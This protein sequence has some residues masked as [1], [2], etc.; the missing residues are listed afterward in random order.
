MTAQTGIAGLIANPASGRDIRRLVAHASVFGND[1]KINIL[2]RVVLGLEAAGVHEVLYMPDPHR[3][4][5]R[6]LEGVE[7]KT[8]LVPVE[9]RLWG[10][11]G[12]T[13]AAARAMQAAGAR[14][15]VSLGGDGTNRALARGARAVPIVPISTGTNNVFPVLI[16]GTVAGLAAGALASGAVDPEQVAPPC[17]CVEISLGERPGELALIDAVV[18]APGFTGSRAIWETEPI[19][20]VVLTR[21]EVDAVGMSAVGGAIH[22]VAPEHDGGLHLTLGLGGTRIRAAIAPGL[23]RTLAVLRAEPL[24]LGTPVRV[25]GP[26]LLALDGERELSLGDGATAHMTVLRS[27]PPVVD[28]ARCLELARAAGFLRG[29]DET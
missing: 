22:P 16:E 29:D 1:E 12:D 21:A 13:E 17:K 10:D 28:I 23:I 3:L 20:E 11:A 19:R 9:A 27:G 15:I 7:T 6:A 26:A 24:A 18:L 4:V 5:P 25:T 2:R 8:R 14:V